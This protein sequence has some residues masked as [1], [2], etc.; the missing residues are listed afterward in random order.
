MPMSWSLHSKTRRGFSLIELLV[1]ISIV[2]VLIGMLLPAVQKVREAASRM[3]CANNPKNLGLASH[4]YHGNHDTF[5]PGAVGPQN[6]LFLSLKHHSLGSYL[7]P[8]L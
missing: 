6:G 1:V 7:L 8:Y 2:A 5:P 4:N 3:A